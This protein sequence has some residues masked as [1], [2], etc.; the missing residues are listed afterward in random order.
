MTKLSS[1]FFLTFTALLIGCFSASAQDKDS[2]LA[3]TYGFSGIELF[4]LDSRAFNLLSGDF[5]S[6]ELTDVIAVD[7]RS[8][9]LRFFRQLPPDAAKTK[10][11]SDFVNDLTSDRRFE[12]Q[13][14]PVDKQIAGVVVSDFN[15]DEATDI[16]YLGAPDR[17]VVRYQPSNGQEWSKRWS[18]RLPD[19]APTSWMI[20]CGDLD[21]NG[22]NDIAVLG[23][24]FTYVIYQNEDGMQAPQQ[25]INTSSQLSLLN[26]ADV[27]AD[28]RADLTYQSNNGATRNLC[29]RLQ[30][31]DGRLGPEHSFGLGQPRSLTVT[32]VDG[33]PGAEVLTIDNRT[34]RLQLSRI[35]ND[36][37]EDATVRPLVRYGIGDAAGGAGRKMAVADI[38]GDGMSDAVV[39]DPENAQLLLYRQQG[40][41]GL[42]TAESYPGL[43]DAAVLVTAELNGKPGAELIQASNKEAVVAV[44]EYSDGRL[45]FPQ[46]VIELKSDHSVVG[47]TVRHD[48]KNHELIVLSRVGK[49]SKADLALSQYRMQSEKAWEA[50]A[51]DVSLPSSRI[52]SRGASVSAFDI[53]GDGTDE[54]LIVP[55]GSNTD[56]I[57]V[58]QYPDGQATVQDPL[59]L[60]V[61]SVGAVFQAGSE[62]LVARD[63][64]A[65]RMAFED[66]K[67]SVADQFNAGES[68]AKIVGVATLNLDEDP[69][70]EVVLIDTGIRRLRLLKKTEGLYRPWKEV[71]LGTFN[72]QS[73]LVADLNRDKRPDLLLFG[74]EQFAVLY[75][76]AGRIS[77]TE[78][79]SWEADRDDAYAADAASGDINGDGVQDLIIIDT[80]IDGLELVNVGPLEQLRSATHFRIFE[81]K[82]LVSESTSRG[83]EPRE[84]LVADVTNDGMAD[85][86]LLCHDRML[87]YPQEVVDENKTGDAQESSSK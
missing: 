43:L 75:S 13:Q 71:E 18:V 81:E 66:G 17:L 82:R 7:N 62:L 38:D 83:T 61:N 60:G 53:D 26:I 76:G 5:N 56:G 15:G 70:E 65:R 36:D 64:F 29:V 44:S 72:F 80:S 41:M 11:P 59:N 6:D 3:A 23:K 10:S 1:P 9:C 42:G 40:T 21:S 68:R 32:D 77:L 37:D 45:T 58:V 4:K 35:T 46:S 25:L 54:V 50:I 87:V 55:E 28:G 79:S 16:A 49:S 63:A 73:S 14:I 57:T 8:S 69:I 85:L 33:K 22:R 20:A 86:V 19:L 74:Q 78:V 67:W 24:Q 84:V 27:N 30:L 2:S 47:M 51:E 39:T 48:G 52:G 34:G 31:D 12:T